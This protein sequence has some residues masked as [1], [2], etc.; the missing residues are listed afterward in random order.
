MFSPAWY[1]SPQPR[2]SCGPLVCDRD[3]W[4]AIRRAFATATLSRQPLQLS[5][6][7]PWAARSALMSCCCLE[8]MTID[9]RCVRAGADPPPEEG[10][11]ATAVGMGDGLGLGAGMTCGGSGCPSLRAPTNTFVA[12]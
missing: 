6:P 7:R 10:F 5:G 1:P 9:G 12:G 3:P 11:L 8:P 4:A 2:S